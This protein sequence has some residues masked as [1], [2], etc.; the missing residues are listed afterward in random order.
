MRLENKVA[1]VTGAGSGIGKAIALLFA[2][3]GAQVAVADI[4]ENAA[5]VTASEIEVSGRKAIAVRVDISDSKQIRETVQQVIEKFG[6]VDILVNNAAIGLVERFTE[7][8]EE[9]WK[10]VIN[11][12]LL[13]TILFS[14]VVLGGMIERRYGKIINIASDAA[15]V[16]STGQVVYS[17]AKGGVI[18][19]TKSLAV[20][21]AQYHV[22]VN[23]VSPGLIETPMFEA[24][25]KKAS[26]LKEAYLHA[27]P[28][29]RTGEPEEIASAVLFLASDEAEYITGQTLSVNGGIVT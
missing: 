8:N 28:W 3:E 1:I 13:G 6:R 22:H 10:K 4:N 27:I 9:D 11:V 18:S 5:K 25:D 20:E 19:F 17:A 24:W 16:G 26:K 7:G 2:R 14:H 15:R 21:M 29:K 23:C 12:N